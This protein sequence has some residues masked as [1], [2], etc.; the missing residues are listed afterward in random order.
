M[1]SYMNPLKV[2]KGLRLTYYAKKCSMTI[3]DGFGYPIME[4]GEVSVGTKRAF[5]DIVS[6]ISTLFQTTMKN[7]VV[8]ATGNVTTVLIDIDID[9]FCKFIKKTRG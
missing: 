7:K 2:T 9:E 3:S 1:T 5:M 4:N 6:T 8:D